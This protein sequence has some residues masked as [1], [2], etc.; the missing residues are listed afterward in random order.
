M[1]DGRSH[2]HEV[3]IPKGEKGNPMS[4]EEVEEKFVALSA[5]VIGA[6]NTGKVIEEL[7]HLENRESLDWVIKL[8]RPRSAV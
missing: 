4:R 8:L 3:M 6:T 1:F 7:N 2:S 5:P